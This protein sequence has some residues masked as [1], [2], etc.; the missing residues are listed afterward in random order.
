MERFNDKISEDVSD[1]E[2]TND[3]INTV[4][5]NLTKPKQSLL[6]RESER[7]IREQDEELADDEELISCT[8]TS[9]PN[10]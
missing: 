9:G 4:Q 1:Q 3:L 7:L 6:D 10:T 2:Q 5:R 8:P